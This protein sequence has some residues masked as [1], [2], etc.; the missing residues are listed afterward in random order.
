M[1]R[2][3]ANIMSGL[4]FV[5]AGGSA[6][7]LFALTAVPDGT[8]IQP[9]GGGA[10]HWIGKTLKDLPDL[11]LSHRVAEGRL[12]A[13]SFCWQ[14]NHSD[15]DVNNRTEDCDEVPGVRLSVGGSRRRVLYQCDVDTVGEQEKNETAIVIRL[16][17][18][19]IVGVVCRG[20]DRGFASLRH[21]PA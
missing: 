20:S 16:V 6:S 14:F 11:L 10:P 4:A 21:R 17:S 18:R 7:S 5:G 19:N 3:L 13:R 12:R 2:Q 8:L 15:G 9:S 1:R